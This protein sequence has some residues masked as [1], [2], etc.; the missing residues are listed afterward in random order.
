MLFRRTLL[1]LITVLIQPIAH[2][3]TPPPTAS[4][5]TSADL[6]AYDV[7]SVKPVQPAR[8]IFMGV[9]ELP[10]G[11]DGENVTVAMLVQ[12]AYGGNW[13]LPTEDAVTGLPDWAKSDRFTVLAKMSAEQTAEFAKLSKDEQKQRR[14]TMLQAL[15]AGSFKLKVHHEAKQVPDYELVVA[16][17]GPKFKEGDGN[18]PDAP[19]GPDGKPRAGSF[20]TFRIGQIRAQAQ[21]MQALANSLANMGVEHRVVDKTGL[22]GKYNFTLNLSPEQGVGP[23]PMGG[24]TDASAPDDAAPSI[25]TALQEQLGLKLRPGTEP[26]DVVVVDHVERPTKD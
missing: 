18:S 12:S 2:A 25:F 9:R 17:G 6:A 23:A 14:E 26:A 16:K 11:I 5:I 20:M 10:D 4:A 1:L 15:L 21:S 8:I 13:N 22:T 3:Q 7:V 24:S 19:M